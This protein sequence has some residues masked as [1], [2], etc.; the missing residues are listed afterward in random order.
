MNRTSAPRP[1]AAYSIETQLQ[2]PLVDVHSPKL[3][4]V[5]LIQLDYRS[6]YANTV[7]DDFPD[8]LGYRRRMLSLK[9]YRWRTAASPKRT[10]RLRDVPRILM[11][12]CRHPP[13]QHAFFVF[14]VNERRQASAQQDSQMQNSA[15]ERSADRWENQFY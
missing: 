5:L 15:P 13:S 12:T 3:L 7:I 9:A 1:V 10:R 2:M 6:P 4:Y 8:F 11:P 14:R